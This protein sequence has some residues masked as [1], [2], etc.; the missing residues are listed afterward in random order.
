[1]IDFTLDELMELHKILL[2]HQIDENSPHPINPKLMPKVIQAI[3]KM[4][5]D[6]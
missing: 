1:M 5:C 6:L 2:A 4:V 3:E